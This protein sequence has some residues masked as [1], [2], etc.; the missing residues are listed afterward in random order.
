MSDEEKD[1]KTESG[2]E[3]NDE[4][5]DV[6]D[7]EDENSEDQSQKNFELDEI[8]IRQSKDRLTNRARNSKQLKPIIPKYLFN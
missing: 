3:D 1:V 5:Q 4:E 6:A 8:K 7:G 2:P